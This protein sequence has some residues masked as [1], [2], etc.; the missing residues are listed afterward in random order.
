MKT[1]DAQTKLFD[2]F[3]SA[4]E[5][6]LEHHAIRFQDKVIELAEEEVNHQS[7]FDRL[8]VSVEWDCFPKDCTIAL[9]SETGKVYPITRE[10]LNEV[11]NLGK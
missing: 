7:L 2:D 8:A 4:M 9:V 11:F 1:S 5:R 6:E 10:K 3:Q